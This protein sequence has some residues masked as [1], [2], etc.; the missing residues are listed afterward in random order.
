MSSGQGLR[1]RHLG[2]DPRVI[3]TQA[4]IARTALEVLTTEGADALSHSRVAEVAGYSKTTVY[5]HWP[6]RLDLLTAALG[7]LGQ[8]TLHEPTGDLRTDLIGQLARFRHAMLDQRLDLVLAAM[9]QWASVQEI[10][11]IRDE[12]NTDGQRPIRTL[13][14]GSFQ[15]A[16]LEAVISMLTGVV[17]CPSLMFGTAPDDDIIAAAVDIVMNSA[18]TLA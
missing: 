9:A 12:I 13:L 3:R 17:A 4:D 2:E 16:R 1:T 5:S 18:T 6:S 10:S 7:A 14:Q 11:Q 15:G 8:S